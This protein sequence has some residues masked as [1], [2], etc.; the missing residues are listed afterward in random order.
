MSGGTGHLRDEVQWL[1]FNISV[2]ISFQLT[3]ILNQGLQRHVVVAGAIAGLVARFVPYLST[4]NSQLTSLPTPR[5]VIA[6]LD[7]LKIRLQLH[8]YARNP[9]ANPS[10]HPNQPHKPA[11]RPPTTFKTLTTILQTEGVRALWKG[12]IPAELLYISYSALQFSTYR[13]LSRLLTP[14]TTPLPPRLI[15]PATLTTFLCGALAGAAA[16]TATYPL[17]LLRTRFAA[18]THAGGGDGGGRVYASLP[19]AVREIVVAEK[20]VQGLFRGLPAALAQIV[21]Y[22]GLF[23]A[24]YEGLR[25]GI[26]AVLRSRDGARDDA[27]QLQDP[28]DNK[29]LPSPTADALAGT[30]ASIMAKSAVF[31]LDTV[32]KRLQ[33]QGPHR[34]RWA[35][36]AVPEYAAHGGGV[37]GVLKSILRVEGAAGLYRGLAVSL[38]KAAPASAVTMWTYERVLA[39]LRAVDGG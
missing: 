15:P 21:P 22:M 20:G 39:G 8:P 34:A 1:N 5:F 25:P 12:N 37:L 9:P 26:A 24:G 29:R 13:S 36:G 18:Q 28:S 3:L 10:A 14:P 27:A 2:A 30:L 23:F 11:A 38:L 16:T 19:Q 31:P 33:V 4:S 17:D 7:V 35:G 6:P 32:R